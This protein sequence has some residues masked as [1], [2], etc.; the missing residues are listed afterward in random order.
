MTYSVDTSALLD[1][2]VRYYPP[3]VFDTLWKRLDGLVVEGHLL[4]IDEVPR[5]LEKKEDG[6]HK[7]VVARAAMIVPLDGELQQAAAAIING[8]PSL[9]KTKSAMAGSADPFVIALAQVRELTVITAEKSKPTKP[10]IPDV[11]KAL[12]VPCMTLVE[13]F[14]REG[15]RV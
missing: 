10:R 13:L 14:R 11:C 3:D 2:W 8:Y 9:T 5:E 4:A 6:L 7:W 12:G 15:W 1:A